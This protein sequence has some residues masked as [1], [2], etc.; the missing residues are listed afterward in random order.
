MTKLFYTT[1]KRSII[2]EYWEKPEITSSEIEV[3]SI[4]TGVCRSD[5]DMYT[6]SFPLLPKTIQ[7]HESLG[8]VTK[9]GRKVLGIKEGD[10]VA[11]RGEP[12]FADIY[13]CKDKMFVKVPEVLPKYIIE[14]VAC[15]VNIANSLVPT[16]EDDILILGSGF[17][18]TIVYTVLNLKFKNHFIVVGSA[19]KEF[20]SSQ[21]NVTH[22]DVNGIAGRKFKYILDLSDKPEYLEMGLFEECANIVLAAEKHPMVKTSF[23]QFLWNAVDIKFPSPRNHGFYDCML[24]SCELIKDGIIDSETLWSKS[25]KRENEVT[26]AFEEAVNRP[27]GYSRGY[28]SWL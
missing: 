22:D 28:I 10:L 11:T 19:N 7:G 27:A 13:N 21:K 24:L 14:P 4:F 18:A 12:A 3:R 25:Y 15:A 9:V 1:G 20:W 16:S 6:G 17:L 5:V 23:S 8:V 26:M 2:E